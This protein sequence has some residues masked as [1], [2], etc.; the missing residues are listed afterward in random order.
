MSMEPREDE[1]K[2][3]PF[4]RS[5][6]GVGDGFR[7]PEG[8][9][10]SLADEVLQRA[11]APVPVRRLRPMVWLPALAAALALAVVAVVWFYGR[12]E[13]GAPAAAAVTL[14]EVSTEEILAYVESNLDDFELQLLLEESGLEEVT[15]LDTL[16]GVSFPDD[17]LDDFS[18]EELEDLL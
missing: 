8:Y 3:A 11:A 12:Q 17:L 5:L 1:L 7:A 6:H 16:P 14:E 13:V 4:L 10:G 2:E 18:V 15:P 9:F